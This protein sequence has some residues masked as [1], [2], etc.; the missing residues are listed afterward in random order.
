MARKNRLNPHNRTVA[1]ANEQE[2]RYLDCTRSK[3]IVFRGQVTSTGSGNSELYR[4]LRNAEALVD[5]ILSFEGSL[6]SSIFTDTTY[7][8]K[9]RNRMKRRLRSLYAYFLNSHLSKFK[10]SELCPKAEAVI[11]AL[12]RL[13]PCDPLESTLIDIR[14]NVRADWFQKAASKASHRRHENINSQLAYWE[15]LMRKFQQLQVVRVDLYH[16]PARNSLIEAACAQAEFDKLPRW[17]RRT[18][19]PRVGT[20]VGFTMKREHGVARGM[21][22]RLMAA[23]RSPSELTEEAIAE[24]IGRNWICRFGESDDPEIASASYF[25]PY[26]R[27]DRGIMNGVGLVRVDDEKAMVRLRVA[28]EAMCEDAIRF[29]PDIC[30]RIG[31]DPELAQIRTSLGTRNLRSGQLPPTKASPELR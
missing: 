20:F 2:L 3:H 11:A 17:L 21:H 18:K 19:S 29:T 15:S 6:E 9:D 25:H 1:I 5:E 10:Y 24:E 4:W 22:F 8:S 31:G 12:K 7:Q 28:I 14:T 16:P 27:T 30:T 13:R 23:F 26:S